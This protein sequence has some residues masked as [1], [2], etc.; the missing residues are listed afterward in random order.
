M[1]TWELNVL[2]QIDRSF[3]ARKKK[4]CEKQY[5]VLF[6]LYLTVDVPQLASLTVCSLQESSE[7]R[8]QRLRL[9]PVTEG[10]GRRLNFTQTNRRSR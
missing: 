9:V 1:E 3:S 2:L 7:S 6:I 8:K 5:I 4:C 10:L